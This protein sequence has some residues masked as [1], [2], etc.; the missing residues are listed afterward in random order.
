MRWRAHA[1]ESQDREHVRRSQ[2]SLSKFLLVFLMNAIDKR[3]VPF[4]V[5]I[6]IMTEAPIDKGID[7]ISIG[8]E[9]LEMES[10]QEQRKNVLC[11][12]SLESFRGAIPVLKHGFI[13]AKLM[14]VSI[15]R[16]K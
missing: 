4:R 6:E 3:A 2:S 7:G 5:D 1:R 15:R 10:L 11:P 16:R 12:D 13:A 9:M 8:N 14:I